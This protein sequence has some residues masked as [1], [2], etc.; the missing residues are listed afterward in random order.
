MFLLLFFRSAPECNPFNVAVACITSFALPPSR[1]D[2]DAPLFALPS[3]FECWT[4]DLRRRTEESTRR[5][6]SP[7]QLYIPLLFEDSVEGFDKAVAEDDKGEE[8]EEE[9][10]EEGDAICVNI[11]IINLIFKFINHF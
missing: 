11:C 4:H 2:D 7:P 5:H 8:Q 10:E 3:F 6:A 1:D 9:E